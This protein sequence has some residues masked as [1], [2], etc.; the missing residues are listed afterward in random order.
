MGRFL[1]V[2]CDC[3]EESIVYG[4]SKSVVNCA[5][6]GANLVTPSG[7]RAKVNGRILEVLQ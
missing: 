1:S 4:D 3:G 7:G 5:K 2:K 6:C